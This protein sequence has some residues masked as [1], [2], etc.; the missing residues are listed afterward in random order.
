MN[1]YVIFTILIVAIL[2]SGGYFC[3]NVAGGMAH[4]HGR[5][6]KKW[7]IWAAF[8]GRVPLAILALLPKRHV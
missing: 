3:A 2:G 1:G 8:W 7:A 6:P 5:P 4:S